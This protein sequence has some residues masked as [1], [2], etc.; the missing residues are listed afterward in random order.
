MP[1]RP[2]LDCGTLT[3][4]P[5]RCDA[6]ERTRSRRPSSAQRYGAHW[7]ELARRL[8]AEH[9][10]AYGDYCPGLPGKI[11]AH[12]LARDEYLTA[13]HVRAASKGGE[14]VRGNVRILCNRCNS[15]KG[16]RPTRPGN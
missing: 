7:T 5:S 6:H 13:D 2:C 1:S 10:A 9:R 11:R 8:V 14:G 4:N 16:N 12:H 15:S 3:R